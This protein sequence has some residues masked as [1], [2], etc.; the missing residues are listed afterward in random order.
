[1]G[2][3]QLNSL[4]PRPDGLATRAIIA[5]QLSEAILTGALKPGTQVRQQELANHYGV[6]RMPVREAIREIQAKGLLEHRPHRS[7]VVAPLLANEEMTMPQAVA[8]IEALQQ[9][10]LQARAMFDRLASDETC[11]PQDSKTLCANE[12]GQIDRVLADLS[13]LRSGETANEE[14]A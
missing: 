5:A 3:A 6:S 14:A 11:N 12:Q 8:R 9:A 2:K 10:L 4:G 1:M 13:H 7:P